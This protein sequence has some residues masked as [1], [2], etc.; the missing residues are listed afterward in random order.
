MSF[1]VKLAILRQPDC[2]TLFPSANHLTSQVCSDTLIPAARL[3]EGRPPTLLY[4]DPFEDT[5]MSISFIKRLV[6]A[7]TATICW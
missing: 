6:S 3:A 2:I 1:T 7:S 5:A 4:F